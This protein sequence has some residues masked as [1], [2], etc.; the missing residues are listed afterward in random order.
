MTTRRSMLAAM[1]LVAFGLPLLESRPAHSGSQTSRDRYSTLAEE[2]LRR[3]CHGMRVNQIS[4]P[5]NPRIHG[6][7]WS[8]GDVRIP[9]RCA[10]A[11]YPFLWYAHTYQSEE[12]LDAA[13]N[14]MEWSLRNVSLDT[15]AWRNELDNPWQGTTVFS[16]IALAQA[17]RFHGHAVDS[18]T[19]ERWLDRLDAAGRWLSKNIDIDFGFINYPISNAYALTLLGQLLDN[20]QYRQ[21][22]KDL[23]NEAMR[24]FTPKDGLLYGEGRGNPAFPQNRS[25]RG[26]YPVDLAYNVEE[27]LPMLVM[28]A[29]FS[30][31]KRAEERLI[32]ALRTHLEFMLP[33]GSWDDSWGLRSYKWT[34]WGS[35]TTDGC[36]PA[37]VLLA[38]RDP[39]FLEAARRNVELL[40]K[41]THNGVLHAGVDLHHR[42]LPP[43]L[44][45]TFCHAKA[46]ATTLDMGIPSLGQHSDKIPR[47]TYYGIKN[48]EDI[49]TVTVSRDP[50][51]ATFTAYD[52]PYKEWVGTHPSGG[53][54]SNLWHRTAGPLVAASMTDYRQVEFS[55]MQRESGS[56][57]GCLTPRVE[58]TVPKRKG[59][60]RSIGSL[61]PDAIEYR[62]MDILDVRGSITSTTAVDLTQIESTARLVDSGQR[63]PTEAATKSLIRYRF[64]QNRLDIHVNVVDRPPS[65][66]LRFILPLISR[67]TSRWWRESPTTVN[68]AKGGALVRVMSTAPAE[69]PGWPDDRLFSFVPGFEALP[70]TF[71][72]MNSLELSIEIL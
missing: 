48:Y 50:W 55:D 23:A 19:R 1:G 16:S 24:W 49:A 13:V 17:L 65:G 28:Y 54:M 68:I 57:F 9:G 60:P 7:I 72:L 56:G 32:E 6:G 33:D 21:R 8:A 29:R 38:D 26:C 25:A 14:V 20:A 31:D 46:L 64:H 34:W 45:H 11:V 67:S 41:C 36:Q 42:G 52:F 37:Y 18:S 53:A 10:D 39:T 15:G 70:L 71:P 4:A 61:S 44:H 22:G 40:A 12:F 35:R 69:I 62:Y 63:P 27:S 59:R 47:E 51:Y 43:S 66:E 5:R 2:L 58:L 30:G 3:W